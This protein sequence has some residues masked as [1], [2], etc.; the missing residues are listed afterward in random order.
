MY[1]FIY[2]H[3]TTINIDKQTCKIYKNHVEDISEKWLL[4]LYVCKYIY[5][6][7]YLCSV[8][9]YVHVIINIDI[10]RKYTFIKI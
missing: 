4:S 3:L 5:I 9:K 6:Y 7:R 10:Y 8:D 2:F 1:I